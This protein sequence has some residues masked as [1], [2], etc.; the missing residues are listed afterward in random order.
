MDVD[1]EEASKEAPS[2]GGSV[3][4]GSFEGGDL[5]GGILEREEAS[6]EAASKEVF[7]FR[8][9]E[10]GVGIPVDKAVT[11]CVFWFANG[12]PHSGSPD[13]SKKPQ[14]RQPLKPPHT[15]PRHSLSIWGGFL[16]AVPSLVA[17]C[18][19]YMQGGQTGCSG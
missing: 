13:I 18:V 15:T 14:N 12:V 17:A 4:G 3:K 2:K 8:I 6:K 9:L 7:Y 11:Y 5:E 19:S 10:I 1:V 16:Q